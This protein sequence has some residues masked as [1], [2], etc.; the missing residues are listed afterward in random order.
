MSHHKQTIFRE[1]KTTHEVLCLV[2]EIPADLETPVSVYLKVR[3]SHPSFLF[4][5]VTGGEQVARYSFVG[6]QPRKIYQ[7]SENTLE[8]NT[9]GVTSRTL[10]EPGQNPL[11]ILRQEL[12][13]YQRAPVYGLPRFS[14]GL[15]GFLGYETVRFFEPGVNSLFSPEGSDLKL[16]DA[17]FL[18]VDTVIAFD[19][20]YGRILLIT[21]ILSYS[22]DEEVQLLSQA[23][24]RLDQLTERLAAPLPHSYFSPEF[25]KT[26]QMQQQLVPNIS[27]EAF[28]Q[29]V[30]NAK[31]FIAA[32]DIFQVVLSQR[33]SGPTNASPFDIYRSLRRLN[34][35][36]Y[37]FFLDFGKT[38]PGVPS[39]LVLIGASPELHVRLEGRQAAI[40]PIA[41]TRPRG[42]DI[43][44]DQNL[45]SDLLADIK[46]RAEHVMLVDLARNDLGRVCRYGSV[47]IPEM[48]AVER[49]SHVMHIVS[50]VV[51]ELQEGLDAFD[52][53]CATFPAGTVS[54]APKVRA[55]QII[56][57]LE[58][59][60]RG[61]YAGAVGYFSMDGSM[62]TCITIRT[63][64]MT[65]SQVHIQA[66][67]GIVA[68]SDPEKEYLETINKSRAL[69]VAV[70]A[71][72]NKTSVEVVS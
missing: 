57:A 61:P 11:E 10:L 50:H 24:E 4:E 55:M 30:Q 64:V 13:T 56:N 34:P 33:F 65:G 27:H 28:L 18:L 2:R 40:R 69:A 47:S 20:A 43:V 52:L 42:K 71:A 46:E 41:G 45:A 72:D 15:V 66:G 35:S 1:Q 32:G 17:I 22:S 51:G 44:E 3:D 19:H 5:S 6:F 68:D 26:T 38:T 59:D 7:I 60:W 63:I 8:I 9:D 37:M 70:A 31:E 23:E 53:M 48:M 36:P 49:Y 25:D 21:N 67:A 58:R 16:P 29:A 39:E 12:Q 54:G 62:D 14:G